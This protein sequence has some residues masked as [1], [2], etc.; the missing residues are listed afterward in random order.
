MQKRLSAAPAP[1]CGRCWLRLL[2]KRLSV[3]AVLNVHFFIRDVQ[4]I[5]E[6][7]VASKEE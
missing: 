2:F 1:P 5:P 6:A 3:T 4:T 7:H